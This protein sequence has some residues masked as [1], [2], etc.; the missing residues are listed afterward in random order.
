ME[1]ILSIQ[2]SFITIC[3]IHFLSFCS[4]DRKGGRNNIF[5]FKAPMLELSLYKQ[6]GMSTAS[7]LPKS[8]HTASI[9]GFGSM[10]TH[11]LFFLQWGTT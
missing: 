2:H 9:H 1:R 11:I 4:L 7:H 5:M 6:L 3:A 8:S 10:D